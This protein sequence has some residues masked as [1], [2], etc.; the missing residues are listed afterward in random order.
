MTGAF[1]E[2]GAV[3]DGGDHTAAGQQGL[4]FSDLGDVLD[5]SAAQGISTEVVGVVRRLIRRQVDAGHGEEGFA[6]IVESIKRPA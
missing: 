6:R 1:A 5:A 2:F 4:A 3:V